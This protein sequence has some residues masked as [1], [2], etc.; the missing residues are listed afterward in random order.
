MNPSGSF[1]GMRW[2]LGLLSAAAVVVL[3]ERRRTEPA[4]PPPAKPQ[5]RDSEP[6]A[7]VG[8]VTADELGLSRLYRAG[9]AVVHYLTILSAGLFAVALPSMIVALPIPGAPIGHIMSGWL[10]AMLA[11]M[12]C[13]V[14]T[15]GFT[16]YEAARW[17]RLNKS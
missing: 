7:V 5:R 15:G 17:E 12:A 1:E 13:L 2:L 3:W 6:P 10:V 14:V 8:P 9:R 11:L 16:G 4:Q